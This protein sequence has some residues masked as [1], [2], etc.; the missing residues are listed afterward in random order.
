MIEQI[1]R[2]PQFVSQHPLGSRNKLGAWLRWLR[3]Q[4]GS[5]LLKA[6]VIMPWLENSSLVVESGMT[7]A[8]GNLYCGLH[9]FN[10]M[11]LVLHFFGGGPG[12][13]LDVGANIGSY[14]I[15]AARVCGASVVALE[16]VPETFDKL[17]RNLLINGIQE[18]VEA[19]RAAV[20]DAPG[21]LSF[22]ADRDTMNQVV[23]PEYAGASIQVQVVTV[24][25]LLKGRTAQ[26]WKVD[27]EGF[28]RQVLAGASHALADPDVALV[29]LEGDDAEI[30]RTMC[31]HGFEE[32]C[33]DPFT[34]CF[35]ASAGRLAIGNHVWV[36]DR[37]QVEKRC[38]A[39]RKF[40][41]H[42][43]EF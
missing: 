30:K 29:L 10:D 23:G 4:L 9:E 13:F 40:Q 1:F 28:E 31:G 34:R 24:D 36:R 43:V 32:L 11:A 18:R 35:S 16:P 8:T 20:G 22:S 37:E 26:V 27:V 5:R 39:A 25:D 21:M 3:W 42:H 38:Q 17:T 12:L 33:Y 2:F 14:S 41:L 6:P 19:N 15:L 7:G